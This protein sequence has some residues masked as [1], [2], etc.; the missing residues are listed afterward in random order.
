M[1]CK[2]KQANRARAETI[3][4]PLTRQWNEWREHQLVGM[5]AMYH[6]DLRRLIAQLTEASRTGST[7]TVVS[8]ANVL[9]ELKALMHLCEMRGIQKSAGITALHGRVIF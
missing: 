5:D 2:C 8:I 4:Y 3:D 7:I 1:H 6:S 9:E